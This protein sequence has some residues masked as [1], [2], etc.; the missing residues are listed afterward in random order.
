M[1]ITSTLPL[2]LLLA[3][4]LPGSDDGNSS[5]A[6]ARPVAEAAQDPVEDPADDPTDDPGDDSDPGDDNDPGGDPLQPIDPPDA[7][8][9]GAPDAPEGT[10]VVFDLSCGLL[11]GTARKA[12]EL[13]GSTWHEVQE[14]G[15][16][17]VEAWPQVETCGQQSD[18]L[19]DWNEDGDI[20]ILAGNM[21]HFNTPNEVEGTWT[22]QVTPRF[23]PPSSCS[24][25]M[26]ALG[27]SWPVT[28]GL[29]LVEIRIPE[30]T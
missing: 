5:F 15:A 8:D 23:D 19:L 12:W 1:R 3:G 4:C 10:V 13:Q 14:P 22:G 27:L 11:Q 24:E 16:P 21:D 28:M 6:Q 30:T 18:K 2:A 29:T 26:A 20:Y 9:A 17:R 7:W 25:G